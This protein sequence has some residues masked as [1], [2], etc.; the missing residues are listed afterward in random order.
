MAD[1]EIKTPA[2]KTGRRYGSVLD[3][4]KGEG[5]TPEVQEK[6]K[7]IDNATRVVDQLA[8]IRQAACIT[9]EQMGTALGLSQS[10][11][12]KLEAGRDEDLTLG[13]IREYSKATGQRIGLMVGKPMN[14]VESVKACARGIQ[15][16]LSALAGLAHQD[17]ELEREI[18]AF[19]GEAFFN[20]LD[21]LAKVHHELP[22]GKEYEVRLLQ[23]L[24][25]PNLKRLHKKAAHLKG[26]GAAAGELTTA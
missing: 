9:Q 15:Y 8:L 13:I 23:S 5:L 19:F 12:S 21:I 25:M 4:M 11:V 14:H 22:N 24:D 26:E 18:A 20:L 1:N 7:E 6:Y 2:K 17:D 16:H 3:L 10:A